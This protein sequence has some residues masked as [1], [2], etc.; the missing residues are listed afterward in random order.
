MADLDSRIASNLEAL[1]GDLGYEFLT[2]DAAGMSLLP[3]LERALRVFSGGRLLDAGAG[4]LLFE[5]LLRRYCET[6]ESLDVIDNPDLDYRGDVQDM[7]IESSRYD[8]V[9]CRNVLEHVEEPRAALEEFGRVLRTGGTAIVSV[10]HLSYLHNE[11]NDFYRFTAHGLRY[12][13]SETD[14]ELVDVR[15]AGGLFSF[16]GWSLSTF[17]LGTTYHLPVV[18]RLVMGPNR[19]LQRL[20]VQ[21]DDATDSP[22]YFPLNYVLVARST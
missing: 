4:D 16:L 6:Y 15:P 10:P 19:P 18:S 13:V 11:P 9:F 5:P 20:L 2:T 8:T 1:Q 14:L 7:E 17:L 12:L 21:L 22:E 3:E